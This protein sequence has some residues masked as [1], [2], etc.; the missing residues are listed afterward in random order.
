MEFIEKYKFYNVPDAITRIGIRNLLKERLSELYKGSLVENSTREE[1]FIQDLKTRAIAE[2]T[3]DANKQHYEVPAELYQA[4]L[5]PWL[6]YSCGYWPNES[7]TFEESE[8]EMLKLVCERVGLDD[9]A[10]GST[11]LDLGCGWGSATLFIAQKYPNLKV[12]CVS[13]SFSQATFI[14]KRAKELGL[15][16]VTTKTADINKCDFPKESF[17]AV[18]TNEMFEH[19]KNYKKLLALVA[20]W[21][22]PGAKLFIH[23]FTHKEYSYHFI[24]GWMAE[25]FF[26][27]G[28]MPST[29]LLTRFQDDLKLLNRY[30][31]NGNHYSKT[32]EA[33]IERLDKSKK[34]LWPMLAKTYGEGEEA[35]WMWNWRL[36]DLACSEL[37]KYNDGEEWFVTHY[38]FQK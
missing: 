2:Q 14:E 20:S 31:V 23:I 30:V 37:F 12:Q 28:T 1:E 9:L 19:M 8:E 3:D 22:K 29:Y 15:T 16:N 6:K 27:G 13:N 33:W 36:F 34:E 5:G 17:D 11:V 35:K 24:D 32:C 21:M 7:T 10:D 18:V 26:T 4:M 25:N 38:V